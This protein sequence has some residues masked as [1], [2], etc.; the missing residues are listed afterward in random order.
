MASRDIR[1]NTNPVANHYANSTERIIEF[2]SPNGGG[3]IAFRLTE[4]GM[5]VDIYR[6]DAT[7]T[8]RDGGPEE[9]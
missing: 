4:V 9:T 7:I 5:F 6:Y 3:L 1:V 2:S 8:V